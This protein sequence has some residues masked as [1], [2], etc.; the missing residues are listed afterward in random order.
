[1][2]ANGD[3]YITHA[4][5]SDL[6]T[7]GSRELALDVG[8]DARHALTLQGLSNPVTKRTWDIAGGADTSLTITG[9]RI[10]LTANGATS[11]VGASAEETELGVRLTFNF[12]YRALRVRIARIYSCV[13]GSP[14]IETWT[15]IDA[16]NASGPVDVTNLVGWT[17]LMPIAR[18]RWL[19]GLRGDAADTVE[20][21]A[22][23]LAER[24]LEPDERLEIGA[25]R[26]STEQFIPFVLVDNDRDE[27]FGGIQWSGAWRFVFERRQDALRVT[28]DFPG[29]V[30]SVG[31]TRPL[32]LPHAFFG[33]TARATTDESGALLPFIMDGIRQGRPF[34]P[35]VTY[36]SWFAYGA[37]VD[38]DTM[39]VAVDRASELGVELFVMDAGW[40]VGAGAND[41]FD[42]S[43]GLGSW[44]VDRD[45]F[46][47]SLASLADYTHNHG[48]L[49]GLWVE[50]E[51]VALSTVNKPGLAQEAWLATHDGDYGSSI[52]AQIC[53]ARPEA[54][55]WVLDKLVALI[56][57]VRPDYLKWDNNFWINCDRSGHGHGSTD[58]NF[59]HVGALYSLLDEIRR[60]Y[61]DLLIENVS[62]G[63]NRLDFGMLGYT[64]VAWMSDRSA[65]AT[66][67]RH[68]IE[69]LTSAF[70]P[71]YLLSF[72]IDD[73]NE[74]IHGPD[75]LPLLV[76]SRLPAVLGMTFR[77][78]DVDAN[79]AEELATEIRRYKAY[80]AAL[81]PTNATLLS[82][83][84]PV[85]LESW[86]VLQE[87]SVDA[88]TAVIFAYKGDSTD[89]RYVVRPRYL[90][91]DVVYDVES[92]DYGPIGSARGDL[93]MTDGVELIHHEGSRAHMI[94]LR[95]Q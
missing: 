11:F 65:P 3:A 62:G 39:V 81:G 38:E 9:E 90:L 48:M 50:P 25:D 73:E 18:V 49:F 60:R 83:Q 23:A 24:D 64:D 84:A 44:T 74:S 41:E 47:A 21:G 6:W 4:A 52:G 54:R 12:E 29:V 72:V 69:G 89:G 56:D 94:T 26:R 20:S 40:Y 13:P 87:M 33:V 66:Q 88:K 34:R 63:G 80:R 32:E 93:L 55:Q 8:F 46:P 75:D 77:V 70:P 30:T 16:S 51:R 5:S 2:A 37:R 43:S 67:V 22:F 95:A 28:A 86:D 10:A 45:R 35:L 76:R 14:T 79:L 7:I 61:P 42:F 53:L 92:V 68:N 57:S 36:N 82:A 31:P 1:M 58:G 91:P 85:D 19:G 27:F 15:R 71:E 78:E 17:M 59:T